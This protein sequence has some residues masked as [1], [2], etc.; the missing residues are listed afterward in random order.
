MQ[1]LVADRNISTQLSKPCTLFIDGEYWSEYSILERYSTH[2]IVEHF[3]ID[4]N[5]VSMI[6][7]GVLE[8]GK[9]TSLDD[10]NQLLNFIK[11]ND[12]STKD[13]YDYVC[14]RIDIQSLIDY[15]STQIYL[16]N[17]DFSYRKNVQIWRSE[18]KT[19]NPYEDGTENILTDAEFYEFKNVNENKPNACIYS[20]DDITI[21]GNVGVRARPHCRT[22]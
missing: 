14:E 13:N 22:G 3:G 20:K 6:K 7:K 21:K 19:D 4:K 1:S 9:K 5:N 18:T 16:N 8:S 10:Y 12:V 11:N 17:V 15:Y 2:Y